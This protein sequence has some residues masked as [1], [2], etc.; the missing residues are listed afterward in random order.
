MILIGYDGS[1]VCEMAI[2]EAGSLLGGS[3]AL[4]VHVWEPA[5]AYELATTPTMTPA[6]MDIRT[7][8]QLER[9]MAEAAQTMAVRGAALAKEAGFDAEGLA[10]ADDITVAATLLR[11]A[12]ERD[13][14]AIVVGSHGHTGVREA[15][16]GSTTHA[17]V[18]KAPC[19]VVVRGPAG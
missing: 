8:V 18:R 16:L 10:V 9:T 4:V 12:N 7:A 3:S 19:L 17:L 13:V 1:D 2:K 5:R 14:T 11:L 6:P 15:V